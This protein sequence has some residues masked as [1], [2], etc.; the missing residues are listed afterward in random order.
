[1]G[2]WT[3]RLVACGQTGEMRE[4][5]RESQCE[6]AEGEVAGR[7]GCFV[8]RAR[9]TSATQQL[10]RAKSRGI[11]RGRKSRR[12]SDSPCRV[13]SHLSRRAQHRLQ[14]QPTVDTVRRST[15]NPEERGR[16]RC[17]QPDVGFLFFLS[18]GR[19]I[20]HE[21]NC[22]R[23]N[24]LRTLTLIL[25]PLSRYSPYSRQSSVPSTGSGCVEA[26]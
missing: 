19:S 9:T 20:T 5:H 12:E 4:L 17:F 22:M 13:D 18:Q 21:D 14:L 25:A 15:A 7:L 3:G 10:D 26:R 8:E 6:R 1:V 11:G 16:M 23:Q 2:S 24:T